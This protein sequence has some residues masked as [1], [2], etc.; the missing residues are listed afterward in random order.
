[1][2]SCFA[3]LYLDGFDFIQGLVLG[4]HLNEVKISSLPCND[5]I[6]PTEKEQ[7]HKVFTPCVFAL[8]V[9]NKG[10][11]LAHKAFVRSNAMLALSGGFQILR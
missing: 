11:G 3:G 5:F 7:T 6:K 2:K 10:L 1:M 4:L 9:C 8:S